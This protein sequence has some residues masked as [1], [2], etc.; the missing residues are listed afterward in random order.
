MPEAKAG[1]RQRITTGRPVILAAA[2]MLA[3]FAG[4]AAGLVFDA[5]IVVAL[6]PETLHD[7]L[8]HHGR[9]PFWF[10]VLALVSAPPLIWVLLMTHIALATLRRQAVWS[11]LGIVGA[12]GLFFTWAL[13][14]Q[15]AA[16]TAA[17]QQG[18]L[19]PE[20][21][22]RIMLYNVA[23]GVVPA[24]GGVLAFWLV[25]RPDRGVRPRSPA[26]DPA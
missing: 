6:E 21:M 10:A 9:K 2:L 26:H 16:C 5:G 3:P 19:P 4:A 12:A 25:L 20:E 22:T 8:R 15:W 7:I 23:M 11:H 18:C 13:N 14:R 24:I 1:L 17:L